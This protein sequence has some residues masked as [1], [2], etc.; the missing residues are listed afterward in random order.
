M[1]SGKCLIPQHWTCLRFRWTSDE[2]ACL[3]RAFGRKVGSDDPCT[4]Y[5]PGILRFYEKTLYITVD[6]IK[7][8]MSH[9]FML[10][11]S[12]QCHALVYEQQHILQHIRNNHSAVVSITKTS[13]ASSVWFWHI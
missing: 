6:H 8:N 3:D 12:G 2:P 11:Q 13:V 7:Q 1:S 4:L 5:Q 10:L 9:N